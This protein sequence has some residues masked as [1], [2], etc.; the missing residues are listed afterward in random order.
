MFSYG[1]AACLEHIEE[2]ATI[3]AVQ[4]LPVS[5]ARW[6]ARIGSVHSAHAFATDSRTP[7]V[8]DTGVPVT[9]TWAPAV[10]VLPGQQL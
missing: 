7:S 4:I 5:D 8:V 10:R 9:V 3:G 2:V 1:S 6:G